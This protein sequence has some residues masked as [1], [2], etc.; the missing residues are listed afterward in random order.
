M[1]NPNTN[2]Q[3]QTQPQSDIAYA[4]II[5]NHPQQLSKHCIEHNNTKQCQW[6]YKRMP[7]A[8]PMGFGFGTSELFDKL[9]CLLRAVIET[10]QNIS[11]KH[12]TPWLANIY[13]HHKQLATL[14]NNHRNNTWNTIKLCHSDEN[15]NTSGDTRKCQWRIQW[16]LASE[17]PSLSTT[18]CLVFG[19]WSKH[20][21]T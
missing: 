14:H 6:R 20:R 8:Y 12:W 15:D 18:F 10:S 7:V 17:P 21:K 16:A 19:L 11:I 4:R 2:T 3:S 5:G 1:K 9:L 13:K